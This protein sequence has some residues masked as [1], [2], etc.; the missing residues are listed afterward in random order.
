[1]MISL[2]PS[3]KDRRLGGIGATLA[4]HALLL[5]GWH[6]TR[7]APAP[8]AGA[9]TRII[10]WINIAPLIP[11]KPPPPVLVSPVP[12]PAARAPAGKA[13]SAPSAVSEPDDVVTATAPA[14]TA[15]PAPTA[16]EMLQRA[17]RDIGKIDQDLRK[18]Y[19]GQPIT[20]P[21]RNGATRLAQGIQEAADLAPNNWY[22]APKVTEII[23]PGPYS[24]R[25]YRVVSS[26]GKPYCI[27]IE[28]N[29]APDGLD[30]MKN[31]LKPKITNCESTEQ[32]A[33]KQKWK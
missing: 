10:Q 18:A 11:L 9:P 24:R 16:L 3:T 29:H 27:T 13:A 8:E 19:P 28:S 17:K 32:A 4:I 31:G 14:E 7:Q 22:E 1:M 23:D 5:Y 2:A 12:P 30:T 20:A 33:T 6:W 25:R 26:G 21:V 15:A